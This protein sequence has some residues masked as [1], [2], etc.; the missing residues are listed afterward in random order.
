MVILDGGIVLIYNHIVNFMI[1][2][3]NS[4]IVY[5]GIKRVIQADEFPATYEAI[6]EEEIVERRR[7]G[8]QTTEPLL[9]PNNRSPKIKQ[10][11]SAIEHNR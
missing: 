7:A 6:H 11:S 8:K 3:Q 10:V 5:C 2:H 1:D 4:L 9:L